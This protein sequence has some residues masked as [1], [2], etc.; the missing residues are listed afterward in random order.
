VIVG[1]FIASSILLY[2]DSG[3]PGPKIKERLNI[4]GKVLR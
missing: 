1:G 2:L 4:V 3:P